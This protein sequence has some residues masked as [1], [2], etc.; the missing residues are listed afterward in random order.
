LKKNLSLDLLCM[1]LQKRLLERLFTELDMGLARFFFTNVL[2]L[3]DTKVIFGRIFLY[4]GR[5]CREF[6]QYCYSAQVLQQGGGVS[7]ISLE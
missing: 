6:I 1:N 5:M 7:R 2:D 3:L 4:W